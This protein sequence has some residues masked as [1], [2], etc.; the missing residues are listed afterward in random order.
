MCG[1]AKRKLRRRWESDVG[2]TLD[3][4]EGTAAI[5]VDGVIDIACAA[6]LKTTLLDALKPGKSVCVSFA[7]GA[8]LDIT[9][10]QLLLAAD[11]EARASGVG[12]TLAGSMP[13]KISGALRDA[14]IEKFP[15]LT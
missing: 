3:Q 2:I 11:R 10:F 8:D 4:R 6:E 14:G 13:E 9:A 1:P 12:F 5:C 15:F 7:A